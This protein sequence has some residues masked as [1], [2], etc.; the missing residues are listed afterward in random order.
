[1]PDSKTL[2]K[3]T[4]VT[5]GSRCPH[6]S[7]CQSNSHDCFF[8]I[9]AIRQAEKARDTLRQQLYTPVNISWCDISSSNTEPELDKLKRECKN[10]LR[11]CFLLYIFC[12]LASFLRLASSDSI[13]EF[14]FL[15]RTGI[16]FHASSLCV[17]EIL[18]SGKKTPALS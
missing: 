16:L 12:N 17:L 3:H 7:K 2:L 15:W 13:A 6:S 11:R 14:F 8:P 18:Q 4:V 9:A 5:H 10:A 1:M